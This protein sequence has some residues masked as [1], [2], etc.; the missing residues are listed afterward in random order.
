MIWRG[1]QGVLTDV[2][3]R[4][5]YTTLNLWY[6]TNKIGARTNLIRAWTTYFHDPST[7]KIGTGANL[8]GVVLQIERIVQTDLK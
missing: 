2:H 8:I 6:G 4:P 1:R 5:V 7:Y 3:Q